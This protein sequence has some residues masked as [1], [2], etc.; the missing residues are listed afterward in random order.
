MIHRL[1]IPAMPEVGMG[2]SH[3]RLTLGKKMP[4]LKNN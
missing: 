4:Y 1:V 3:L 2:G